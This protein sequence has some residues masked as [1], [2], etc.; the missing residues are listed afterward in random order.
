VTGGP[1][2]ARSTG[3]WPSCRASPTPRTSWSGWCRW[4]PRSPKP[5]STPLGGVVGSG[6][7]GRIT[8]IGGLN[9]PTTPSPHS[10]GGWTTKAH[11]G[12][13]RSGPAAGG[14][15]HAGSG[16]DNPQLIGVLD[17]IAVPTGGR[18][19]SRAAVLI[20]DKTYSHPS[21]RKALRRRQIRTVI[22]ERS[23]QKARRTARKRQRRT[24]TGPRRRDLQATQRRRT[25]CRGG[26]TSVRRR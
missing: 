22:P 23:D 5:T 6:G 21:T 10:R 17:D 3:C 16:R 12:C 14:A 15:A 1:R 20:A 7:R 13:R 25:E 2:T 19:R 24:P 26:G 11:A 4:T 8:R 18:A 9:L